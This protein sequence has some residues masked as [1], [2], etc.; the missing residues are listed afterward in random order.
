MPD[1]MLLYALYVECAS[2]HV[3]VYE[4]DNSGNMKLVAVC[5]DFAQVVGFFATHTSGEY[6]MLPR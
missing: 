4:Y 1:F 2:A 6:V 3:G 5:K